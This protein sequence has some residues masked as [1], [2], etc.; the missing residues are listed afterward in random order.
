MGEKVDRPSDRQDMP[1]LRKIL[2][3]PKPRGVRFLRQ[4]RKYWIRKSY[5]QEKL[6]KGKERAGRRK[7]KSRV[8]EK[9]D[10]GKGRAVD[11]GDDGGNGG[12]ILQ[13]PN[14][15]RGDTGANDMGNATPNPPQP[16]MSNSQGDTGVNGT[17]NASSGPSQRPTFNGGEIYLSGTTGHEA[18]HGNAGQWSNL[19]MRPATSRRVRRQ[20][21]PR[22]VPS[23]LLP[24][25]EVIELPLE[26]PA[27]H[28]KCPRRLFS[29][30]SATGTFT[31]LSP[32]TVVLRGGAGTPD[33]LERHGTSASP[34]AGP[35]GGKG[36]GRMDSET[37]R[38][39]DTTIAPT[40]P[41]RDDRF[42]DGEGETPTPPNDVQNTSETDRLLGSVDGEGD[43]PDAAGPSG[44]A[45]PQGTITGQ[46]SH[47]LS[48]SSEWW[49]R[50]A[51][52]GS[53]T[54]KDL[55]KDG[56]T[57]PPH[58]RTPS[59]A[60]PPATPVQPQPPQPQPPQTQPPQTQPP[61]PQPPQLGPVVP[62][63]KRARFRARCG[64]VRDKFIKK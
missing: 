11:R 2:P 56:D 10:K 53:S 1:S 27:Y 60:P 22:T 6:D 30:R 25:K 58:A 55:M 17:D 48:R 40:T 45:E 50:F 13:P 3:P 51:S 61:Q 59:H 16:P 52:M 19:S 46:P 21:R 49:I 9:P 5:P 36:K 20:R 26:H 12:G 14:D 34:Q 35:A 23:L 7:L 4:F 29:S 32:P 39:S 28:I 15:S 8:Q 33:E 64:R 63:G 57:G 62:P 42:A 54:L 24:I 43:Q 37:R 47:V 18:P 41:P 44:T 31:L 38:S